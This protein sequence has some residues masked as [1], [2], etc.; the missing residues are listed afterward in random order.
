MASAG[1][2]VG[3]IY[4]APPSAVPDV[5]ITATSVDDPE[6]QGT[7][8]IEVGDCGCHWDATISGAA[9]GEYSGSS[10]TWVS[11]ALSDIGLQPNE[12][13][14]Y[15]SIHIGMFGEFTGTGEYEANVSSIIISDRDDAYTAFDLPEVGISLPI[16]TITTLDATHIEGYLVGQL[17]RIEP[18]SP[19]TWSIIMVNI[20][21][22]AENAL[23]GSPCSGA[24]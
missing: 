12:V 24:P 6:T 10:A 19:P 9:G 21:F 13:E 22:R 18:G 23:M 4:T 2:F 20:S 3:D 7:A 14:H 17:A 5:L 8:H 16:L 15:P 11:S 1:G